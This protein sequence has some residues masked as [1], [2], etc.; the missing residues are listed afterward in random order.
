[1]TAARCSTAKARPC[2]NKAKSCA[3]PRRYFNALREKSSGVTCRKP[4]SVNA[5]KRPNRWIGPFERKRFIR[6]IALRCLAPVPAGSP[7]GGA[8]LPPESDARVRGSGRFPTH[9][10][11]RCGFISQQPE[12][13]SQYFALFG[14]QFEQ[15]FDDACFI[16]S[17]CVVSSGPLSFF[18]G[19]N[20]Q[21]RF[22]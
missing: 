11:K 13:T 2:R 20:I 16:S 9:I 1:M 18:I 7:A 15:P 17:S 4:V 5:R 10:F 22:F 21:Q 6:G 14:V 8:G 12:T 3:G 19:Q